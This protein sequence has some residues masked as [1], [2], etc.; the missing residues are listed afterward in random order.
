MKDLFFNTHNIIKF[1]L[2]KDKLKL[3]IW[4]IVLISYG[5]GFVPIFDEI[6]NTST[7]PQVLLDTM[8]NP[9]MIA[10][11]GPVFVEET[12]TIGSIY[13]NYMLVFSALI[14]GA[15]NI[16]IISSN[17]RRDEELGRVELLR[18]LPVGRLSNLLA[19]LIVA[20]FTNI[21]ILIVTAIGMFFISNGIHLKGA[22]IFS[23]A[24]YGYGFLMGVLTALFGEIFS[25]NRSVMTMSF[26]ALFI[27]YMLRA[28]GDVSMDSLSLI[29]PLGLV[30]RTENFVNDYIWPFYILIIEILVLLILTYFFALNRDVGLGIIPERQ[31]RKN[32]SIFLTGIKSFIFRLNRSS[33][34]IWG[35]VLFVFSA[36]Y[37]SV[38]GDLENYISTSE[39]ISDMFML[40]GLHSLTEQFISL[41]MIIMAMI[42]TIPVLVILHRSIS[43]EQK[44]LA[45]GIL[46]KPVS[47]FEYLF[48]FFIQGVVLTII[49]Q[50]LIATGFW[51]I[52]GFF[53][54]SIPSLETFLISS[55]LYVP[56]IW[57]M[58]GVSTFLIGF[59][60]KFSW[61]N[62]LYLGFAFIA[63]Y[64]GKLLDLPE[65]LAYITPFG[66]VIS[67]PL[68]EINMTSSV[69]MI[70]LFIVLSIIGFF[71]YKSRDLI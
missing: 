10:M 33:I 56:A 37:G 58:I 21:I 3:L 31:G 15:M 26:L 7:N 13:S 54:D 32:A 43:E 55:L 11:I 40:D 30:T 24:I 44:G 12:Y 34:I 71:G 61:L 19:S 9:A 69:I 53:L 48:S 1:I 50:I 65:I 42:S 22:F 49:F 2:K 4:I 46:T 39:M 8:K 18:S 51:S 20:F 6:L 62:Y 17:T 60:P 52:G 68:E 66:N 29:S 64:M 67:Y 25:N 41:L 23:A 45:E 70:G 47:R 35:I 27:T 38:F 59:F 28:I 63:V 16:F 14:A 5:V 36:M 57:V